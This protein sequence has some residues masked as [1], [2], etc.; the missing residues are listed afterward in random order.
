MLA[1]RAR[2]GGAT[3]GNS[4]YG[5]GG[6]SAAGGFNGTTDN[7]KFSSGGC[8]PTVTPTQGGVNT[9]TPTATCVGGAPSWTAGPDFPTNIVRAVGVYY[10]GNSRFY[11]LGGRTADGVGNDVTRPYEFN[12]ATNS[13]TQKAATFSNVSVNNMA[14]GVMTI[15]GQSRIVLV[16]GSPGGLVTTSGD[17]R[18]YDPVADTLTVLSSDPWPAGAISSTIPGGFAVINNK[19][20]ILGG[21]IPTTGSESVVDTIWEF[22]P[23]RAAGQMWRLKNARLPTALAYLPAAAI[24]N[25]IYTGGGDTWGGTPATLV[26]SNLAFRYDPTADAITSLPTMALAT[27]ETRG[28]N[29]NGRLYV[30][31]GGRTAPNPG[32]TVQI[33]DPATNAWTTGAPFTLARRNFPADANPG[34]AIYL[35]GGYAPT[36]PVASMEIFRSSGGGCASPTVTPPVLTNTPTNIPSN[37][38]TNTPILSSTPTF[39]GSPQSTNTN[40]PTTVITITPGGITNTPTRT[41]TPCSLSFSDVHPSDFFYTSVM[42]LAC[43][44]VI[45]GYAD[46]TFR[47]F[48]DITRGQLTKIV[49]LAEGWTLSCPT[50]HFNDVPP[51]DT[52]FC[53]VETAYGHGVISG[54]SDGTFRPYNNV[55]RGQIC[56]VVVL[57]ET[58]TLTCPTQHFSDVPPTDTFFCYIET[59]FGHGIISGYADGTFRPYNNTT[60]G[61]L[62]KIV[63]Q[64]ITAP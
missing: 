9:S 59:A 18:V 60:R 7:Q 36:N 45:S 51:T 39:T 27:G 56:K 62:S 61:Q 32:N 2:F 21:F 35:A 48:N 12:P 55:T 10:P 40:T 41:S 24:G 53:Y 16:G 4:F 11:A 64:A 6:R 52:F 14:G 37:T 8:V 33:Y 5:I 30:L 26:D 46:G 25:F 17:V 31:G 13:W 63:Y 44:G 50:Q 23:T 22:D 29:W 15:G 34:T 47:P 28:V 58:W 42:Y 20:Y 1:E 54:Y 49:V 57:A 3:V 38:P 19:M 43:H